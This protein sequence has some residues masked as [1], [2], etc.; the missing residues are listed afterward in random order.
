MTS[1]AFS[2]KTVV[3][4]VFI[5][6][7]F[8]CFSTAESSQQNNT[9]EHEISIYG[10]L[11][12][13]DGNVLLDDGFQRDFTIDTSEILDNLSMVFMGGYRGHYNRWSILADVVYMD[14]DGSSDKP[15]VLGAE[16]VDLNISS[17][18]INGGVGYDIIQSDSGTLAVIGGLRYLSLDV[19]LGLDILNS[20]VAR[21]SD[22]D[23]ILDG[24]VGLGGNIE[25]NENWFLPYHVDIGTG[26]SNF[27]WQAFAAI[28]YRFSWGDIRLGYRYLSYD[29]DDGAME[30][31][32]INGPLL[33]VGF[34]F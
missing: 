10:W 31:L 11:A 34:R 27:T 28:G 5:L 32:S 15:L 19:D 33:G 7:F 23:G 30:D 24:I 17:W 4:G 12:G 22:S 6:L 20:P 18:I 13:I 21:R 25:L 2:L 9:W 26:D 14:V 1:R 8:C 16:S 29:F 3:A